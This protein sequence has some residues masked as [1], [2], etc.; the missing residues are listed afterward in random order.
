MWPN[1]LETSWKTSFFVQCYDRWQSLSTDLS[2][3]AKNENLAN[4]K[5]FTV[6]LLESYKDT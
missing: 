5:L 6:K 3:T 1:P 4:V 2:N